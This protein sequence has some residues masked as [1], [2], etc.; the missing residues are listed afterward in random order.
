MQALLTCKSACV[1]KA[2]HISGVNCMLILV[3]GLTSYSSYLGACHMFML[4]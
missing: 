1:P 3:A 2:V 4:K